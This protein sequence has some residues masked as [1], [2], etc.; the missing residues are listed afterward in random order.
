MRIAK[1]GVALEDMEETIRIINESEGKTETG[2]L[3]NGILERDVK[4]SNEGQYLRETA[5]NR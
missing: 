5:S 1:D 3:M 2:S 4:Q